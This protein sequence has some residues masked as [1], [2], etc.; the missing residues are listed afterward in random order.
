MKWCSIFLLFCPIQSLFINLIFISAIV[1]HSRDL[2]YFFLI[3]I[4]CFYVLSVL[5]FC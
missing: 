1:L 4:P 2:F 3:G 5:M